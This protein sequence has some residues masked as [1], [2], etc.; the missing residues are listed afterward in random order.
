MATPDVTSQALSRAKA[1]RA[2]VGGADNDRANA[3]DPAFYRWSHRVSQALVTLRVEYG[4]DLDQFV[5]CLILA[6]ADLRWRQQPSQAEPQG[7]NTLSIADITAIP[8]ASVRRKL[9][10]LEARG[11]AVR[12]PDRL[13]R[14]GPGPG[15]DRI[16]GALRSLK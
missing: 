8:R 3:A 1:A 7:M 9:A 16:Y 10:L 12:G 14:L 4:G 15:F 13:Y 5:I 11:L 2:A 6:L